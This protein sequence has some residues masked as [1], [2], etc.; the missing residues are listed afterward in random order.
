MVPYPISIV[1]AANIR[2]II[3]PMGF[4]KIRLHRPL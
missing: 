1:L 3:V 4:L 2:K